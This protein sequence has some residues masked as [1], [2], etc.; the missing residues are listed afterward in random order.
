MCIA[1]DDGEETGFAVAVGNGVGF[2]VSAGGGNN[3]TKVGGE[4]C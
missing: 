4:A 1:V 3:C 2:G